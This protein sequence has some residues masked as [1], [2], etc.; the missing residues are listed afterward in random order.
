VPTLRLLPDRTIDVDGVPIDF[1][2]IG[3]G[4]VAELLDAWSVG[5]SYG[6]LNMHHEIAN[7]ATIAM[8][9]DG[10][11]RLDG[12][13]AELAIAIAEGVAAGELSQLS[14][15]FVWKVGGIEITLSVAGDAGRVSAALREAVPLIRTDEAADS[16]IEAFRDLLVREASELDAEV[17]WPTSAPR[18]GRIYLERESDTEFTGRV[19]NWKEINPI[20]VSEE[21]AA[22]TGS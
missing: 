13:A 8:P 10:S 20:G 19:P 1:A 9:D 22:W 17:D 6:R 15:A 14:A 3:R 11:R 21:I 2:E 4:A 16:W 5:Q 7:L 18:L 12:L